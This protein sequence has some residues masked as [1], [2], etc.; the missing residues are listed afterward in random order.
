[1]QEIQGLSFTDIA[2]RFGTPAYVYDADEI[3]ATYRRLRGAFDER[4]QL[5][6]SLKPNPNISVVGLL[7]SLGA[8]AEVCSLG[9][10]RSALAAGVP[11][12]RILM[13][14]PGKSVEELTELVARD[15]RAV[16][17]ESFAELRTID[18]IAERLGKR[19][20]VMLRVNPA[21][22]VE[23]GRLTM[24]G[25]PRQFGID[26]DLVLEATTTVADHPHLDIIGVQIYTGTRILDAE[27]IVGNT[28]RALDLAAKVATKLG[29]H[30]RMV[31][32]GGGI[33]LAYFEGESDPDEEVFVSGINRAARRF[34]EDHPDAIIAM[35]PGRYL[36]GTAGV[37]VLRVRYV[38]ESRGQR[39]AVT[40]GGSNMNMSAIGLGTY[41]K[42]NFPTVL[43]SDER[44][45]DG[46]WSV[47]GPLLTPTDVLTKQ[48]EL[49]ELRPGDL[50]GILRMG[51]YGPTASIAYMNGQGYP[52]EIL[53]VDGV[54]HLV[55]ERDTPDDLLRKQRLV[56]FTE[57][58]GEDADGRVDIRPAIADVLG[59]EVSELGTDSRLHD[60]LHL[61][62]LSMVE[63]VARLED[64]F[65]IVVDPEALT[66]AHFATVDSLTAY[67]RSRLDEQ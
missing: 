47:T 43:L 53:V 48:A 25:R 36:V 19:P 14:G 5:F 61:D 56:D 20:K 34:L 51:A 45:L 67:V 26:E 62:S 39:Y 22:G 59:R 50:V 63:L 13:T 40:D 33:G 24:A 8:G 11:A 15:V 30:V 32:L 29:I 12:D 10:L 37:C 54:A 17:C 65:K 58:G 60:D 42:R 35:E 21:H 38:K 2:E 6:Y 3:T 16:I 23:G 66:L 7:G 28:E 49:P 52:A 44:P 4:I 1:M 57:G 9:E 46:K 31:D 18:E 27:V 64:E 55:R 41:V